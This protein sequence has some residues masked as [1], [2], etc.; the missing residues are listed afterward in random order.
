MAT[1][2]SQKRE[3]ML[4][5]A[6]QELAR[7]PGAGRG[8]L[9]QHNDGDWHLLLPHIH[10]DFIILHPNGVSVVANDPTVYVVEQT[11]GNEEVRFS[12][13]VISTDPSD[14][15]PTIYGVEARVR[16]SRPT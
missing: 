7:R 1:T 6:K 2:T 9:F 15:G 14:Y 5:F 10:T 3:H 8:T 12:L 16:P 4:R 13:T 11:C